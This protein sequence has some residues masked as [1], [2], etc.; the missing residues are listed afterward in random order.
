MWVKIIYKSGNNSEPYEKSILISLDGLNV[1]NSSWDPD[2][3]MFFIGQ[4]GTIIDFIGSKNNPEALFF[5]KS[6]EPGRN[7]SFRGKADTLKNVAAMEIALV[8]QNLSYT[9]SLMDDFCVRKVTVL[10]LREKY[11]EKNQLTDD[12]LLTFAGFETSIL[13]TPVYFNSEGFYVGGPEIPRDYEGLVNFDLL[14]PF[15]PIVVRDLNLN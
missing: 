8:P 3:M 14:E 9:G 4:N 15:I 1:R 12:E 13:G 7:W 2:N 10:E 6:L 5:D 11:P